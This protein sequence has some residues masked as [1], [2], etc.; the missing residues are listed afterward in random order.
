[1]DKLT[2]A[3]VQIKGV[4]KE[5]GLNPEQSKFLAQQMCTL[6]SKELKEDTSPPSHIRII[7]NRVLN[8]LEIT[9]QLFSEEFDD[10]AKA[11]ALDA[12]EE[13]T[14]SAKAQARCIIQAFIALA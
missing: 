2:R 4:L 6:I 11:M 13:G 14:D 8:L 10:I 12:P 7:F 9:D 5:T 1:M 3:G